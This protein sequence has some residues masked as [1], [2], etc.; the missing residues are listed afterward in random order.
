MRSLVPAQVD[1]VARAGD[2]GDEGVHEIGL[3]ADER[4]HRAVV[5]DVGVD[6]E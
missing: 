2:S 3:L 5:I 4:E 6:V 1:P